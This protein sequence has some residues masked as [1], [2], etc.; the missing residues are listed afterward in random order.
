[1]HF[2]LTPVGS[3]GDVHPY[4]GLGRE[5]RSRGHL[6]TI[7]TAEPHRAVVERAGL[8]FVPTFSEEHYHRATLDVDLFHPRRG[9]AT[10]MKLTMSGLEPAWHA[11]EEL[12]E[13]ERTFI[14]GHP[15]SL[16]ARAF[17]EKTGAASATIHLAPSSLRS[18]Y[19]VPALAPGVDISALP[20]WMKR[21]LW[22]AIDLA[23]VD[24]VIT[25][26]LNR[27]RARHQLSP[28]RRI[29]K[30][31]INS[32]RRVIAMF[33]EWFGPRQPDWPERFD[34]AAFPLW[35]DPAG[36]HID[37]G[38]EAF[39]SSGSPPIVATPGSAN[40]HATPFF[41]AIAAALKQ[42]DRRGLFLTGFP[43]QLPPDLP[44]TII[45]RSYAPF[46]EVLPRSAALVHHG[47]IGTLAQGFAAGIPHLVMPMAFDQP[48][49]AL[50]ASR[51]G[52]ARWLAPSKFTAERVTQAL[53]ELLESQAVARSAAQCRERVRSVNGL[54][55]AVDVLEKEAGVG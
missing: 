43:E 34:H 17:E 9:F 7:L 46:S 42:L 13:P 1:M 49:N 39:L 53:A 52:V 44:D 27:W 5:L 8:G 30:S 19:K 4:V 16:A 31:W 15:L 23:A 51:H 54:S 3:S 21:A 28:V 6:V 33:P 38:L 37:T 55:L 50:R 20:L 45:A 32:P 22:T 25:P 26:T 36:D 47:G 12:W 11:L 14:V 24:P 29:F 40:R 10:V 35:D 41:A 18:T 48:D 2:L